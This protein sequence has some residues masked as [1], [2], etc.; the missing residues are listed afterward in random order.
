MTAEDWKELVVLE[1]GHFP[2]MSQWIPPALRWLDE[3][4]GPVSRP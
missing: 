3:V 4:L 2:P 1:T